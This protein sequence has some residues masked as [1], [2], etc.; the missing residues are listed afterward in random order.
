MGYTFT[1]AEL[2][3]F[4]FTPEEAF[5]IASNETNQDRRSEY[6]RLYKKLVIEKDP[7][8]K[9]LQEEYDEWSRE[10]KIQS[11]NSENLQKFISAQRAFINSGL[12]PDERQILT[13]YTYQGDGIINGLLRN[14]G[15]PQLPGETGSIYQNIKKIPD[16]IKEIARRGGTVETS[17]PSPSEIRKKPLTE[18]VGNLRP[19]LSK[20]LNTFQ[21]I[22]VSQ[23]PLKVYRGVKGEIGLKLND[24]QFLSTSYTKD[25]ALKFIY[26]E[27]CCLLN[28]TLQ[29]GVRAA[30]IKDISSFSGEDEILVGPPFTTTITKTTTPSSTGK[31]EYDV[32]ISPRKPRAGKTSKRKRNAK[33][34][35]R[36]KKYRPAPYDPSM[37]A[38]M[39]GNNR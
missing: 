9:A 24:N 33:K 1:D 7:S 39:N 34:T 4:K 14:Q 21:K 30:F 22:P 16:D 35:R 37:Y 29:P 26:K 3:M 6:L 25:V 10:Q 31:Q 36:S 12:T 18:I 17:V 19:F 32:V 13:L 11:E 8:K 28:I 27:P 38:F 5:N 20:F 2:K 15:I 23:V